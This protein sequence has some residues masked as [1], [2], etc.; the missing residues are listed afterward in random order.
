MYDCSPLLEAVVGSGLAG[1]LKARSFHEDVRRAGIAQ[2][3]RAQIAAFQTTSRKVMRLPDPTLPPSI[4]VTPP[5]ADN[6]S[7]TLFSGPQPTHRF[8]HKVYYEMDLPKSTESKASL[9]ASQLRGGFMLPSTPEKTRLPADSWKPASTCSRP[10]GS[11]DTTGERHQ[12]NLSF[13]TTISKGTPTSSESVKSR[14]RRKL[15]DLEPST[16]VAP[17]G[18]IIQRGWVSP[19]SSRPTSTKSSP[20]RKAGDNSQWPMPPL[21]TSKS[22]SGDMSS[23]PSSGFGNPPRLRFQPQLILADAADA[24]NAIASDDDDEDPKVAAQHELAC[25]ARPAALRPSKQLSP[26][27]RGILKNS[28][29]S[30]AGAPPSWQPVKSTAGAVTPKV[31]AAKAALPSRPAHFAKQPREPLPLATRGTSGAGRGRRV[32]KGSGLRA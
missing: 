15:Y 9:A 1:R 17:D 20:T 19:V 10:C 4:S 27:V 29:S 6:G 28:S 24:E 25:K 12:R 21:K 26:P 8:R 2:A 14:V 5:Q 23:K 13:D 31:E 32:P 18:C 11:F 3:H 22:L 16:T 7:A 30:S